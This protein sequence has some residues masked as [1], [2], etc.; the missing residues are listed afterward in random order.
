[1]QVLVVFHIVRDGE[2]ASFFKGVDECLGTCWTFFIDDK[3]GVKRTN[4]NILLCLL[5]FEVVKDEIKIVFFGN[6]GIILIDDIIGIQD[7]GDAFSGFEIDDLSIGTWEAFLLFHVPD[8]VGVDAVDAVLSSLVVE[9]VGDGAFVD[10]GLVFEQGNVWL[11]EVVVG[12]VAE[13]PVV[14]VG[15][16]HEISVWDFDFFCAA[17]V[18]EYLQAFQVGD[19]VVEGLFGFGAVCFTCD[20]VDLIV[21][22]DIL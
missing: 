4:Y 1:V 18:E 19:L 20:E 5:L 2:T 9:G 13:D 8:V 10:V 6:P 15:V 16:A 14:G 7:F 11:D 22:E 21:I 12:P 3:W 17:G